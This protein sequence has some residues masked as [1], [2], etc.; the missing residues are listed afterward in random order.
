MTESRIV[1]SEAGGGRCLE[2]MMKE[3][4]DGNVLYLIL[5]VLC[6]VYTCQ[7]SLNYPVKMYAF[8]TCK[9]YLMK[10]SCFLFLNL[11]LLTQILVPLSPPLRRNPGVLSLMCVLV[12]RKSYSWHPMGIRIPSGHKPEQSG[13][14]WERREL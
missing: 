12:V 1:M 9:L 7:N 11:G 4:L 6:G 3:V 8:I 10:A 2:K 5:V 14:L 13:E